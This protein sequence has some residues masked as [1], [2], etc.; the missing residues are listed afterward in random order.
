[1]AIFHLSVSNIS[2]GNGQSVIAAAAYRSGD[3]L[4]SERY[5]KV[6]Y[7]QREIPPE[8]FILK[9]ENA[10]SWV[11]DRAKLWNAVEEVEKFKNARLA[12]EI[13]VALPVELMKGEQLDLAK[14]FVQENFVDEGMVAD[15]S[16]H[17]DDEENPHM[18]IMLTIR[19]FTE[20]G[21]WNKNKS[22]TKYLYDD[23]GKNL[24]TK[25]GNRKNIKVDLIDCNSKDSI[26]RWRRNWAEKTNLYLESNG[27]DN[28]ISEKSN[29]DLGIEK[30]P[31]I[32]EGHIARTMGDKSERVQMNKSIKEFNDNLVKLS[33]YK[34]EIK[35]VKEVEKMT[36][37]FSPAEKKELAKIS[38]ELKTFVNFDSIFKKKVQ[39]EHW[40]K[41]ELFK[42]EIGIEDKESIERLEGEKNIVG[43]ADEIL[44]GEANRFIDK[45]YKGFI[46]TNELSD[47]QKLY[48][49][50]TTVKN[51]KL[52]DESE[53][54]NAIYISSQKEFYSSIMFI[55]RDSFKSQSDL[56]KRLKYHDESL[57]ELVD[58]HGIN[59]KD[60]KTL[61][62]LK[63]ETINTLKFHTL[64]VNNTKIAIKFVEQYYSDRIVNMYP[65]RAN[66]FNE[67]MAIHEKE[68]V[69]S[70]YDYFGRALTYKEIKNLKSEFPEKYSTEV[71]ENVLKKM[72][73]INRL[74]RNDKRAYGL[75]GEDRQ[76]K[77][78]LKGE[79]VKEFSD[80][81]GEDATPAMEQFFYSELST[82]SDDAK[83]IIS[84]FINPE[85]AGK[86]KYDYSK[87]YYVMGDYRKTGTMS[88]L[89][90]SGFGSI[91]K[92]L[93]EMDQ[94][95]NEKINEMN[96]LQQ[97]IANRNK[98]NSGLS[99]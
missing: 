67:K 54:S 51:N 45:N 56:N 89:L 83:G 23:D 77:H 24:L 80:I 20:D 72:S 5:G 11:L 59:F 44:I 74:E 61:D 60:R 99:R 79:I 36:R 69:V 97:K 90:S 94:V 30:K 2:R 87:D 58:K 18:H 71:K 29:V 42:S 9:P 49:T 91:N 65:D 14:E 63:P 15:V 81:F 22:I 28:R 38:K 53:F 76:K 93:N 25:A 26:K 75:N 19:P 3:K 95:E 70:S 21:E 39:I 1:M 85:D 6:N 10:P 86:E 98:R 48:L 13:T 27:F 8:S 7:Y 12:K 62:N 4:Y 57:K 17:R 78:S 52:M 92:V 50:N 31:T 47:Y 88:G 96:K 37:N 40:D 64:R 68:I 84:D 41:S 66:K 43:R 55:T 73:T 32:H 82:F 46:N 33:D 34:K 16:I 35:M